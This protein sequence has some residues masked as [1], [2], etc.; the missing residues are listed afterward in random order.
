MATAALGTGRRLALLPSVTGVARKSR[1]E[2]LFPLGGC[3]LSSWPATGRSS[4][5]SPSNTLVV[6]DTLAA[7]LGRAYEYSDGVRPR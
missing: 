2:I 1:G 3:L 4:M 5:S 6:S 7:L